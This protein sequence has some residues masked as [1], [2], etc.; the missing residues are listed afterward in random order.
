MAIAS[1]AGSD[2]SLPRIAANISRHFSSTAG[3][4]TESPSF[5]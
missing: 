5:L 4:R 3:K 2:S 1:F